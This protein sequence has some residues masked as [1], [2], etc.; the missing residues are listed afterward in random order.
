MGPR[1][2]LDQ[3]VPSEA[4]LPATVVQQ[5][6]NGDGVLETIFV[7]GED[8]LPEHAEADTNQDRKIDLWVQYENRGEIREIAYDRDGDGRPEE[9]EIFEAGA[10]IARHRDTVGNGLPDHWSQYGAD[11]TLLETHRDT[12]ADG[13]PDLWSSY[14]PDASLRSVAY[15]T[16]S[17]GNPDLWCNYSEMGEVISIET[18]TDGDGKPDR[19]QVPNQGQ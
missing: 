2:V 15:D 13:R 11:G 9:W 16:T 19:V 12:D 7:Y 18:D 3:V 1:E 17:T 4:S 14:Y 8:G 10:M 6:L 5:D